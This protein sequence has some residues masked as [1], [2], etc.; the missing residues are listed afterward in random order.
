VSLADA[1]RGATN[2]VRALMW[3]AGVLPPVQPAVADT[4]EAAAMPSPPAP[5]AAAPTVAPDNFLACL[6]VILKSEG[7]F[8]VD[9]GGATNFG[10]T[11][12][13]L[14]AFLHRPCD[15]FDIKALTADGPTV[16]PLYRAD[17]YNAAHCNELAP[18][19]DL[20]VFDEAVNEGVGRGIRHL[21]EVLGVAID[22]QFGPGTRAA[23][24][25]R[26]P[27]AAVRAIHDTNAAYY[28]SLDTKYPR[29]EDGW[30]ARNDRTRDLA[31]AMVRIGA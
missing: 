20:M 14:Q 27:A 21:Q 30:Q 29:D 1:W 24:A 10:I 12:P 3:P 7:G 25:T 13:A 5:A 31:L 9:Q 17:Y 19:L 11:I 18:G 15:V 6:A 4:P 23:A 16:G 2:A 8:V 22:G 28:Q 26:D